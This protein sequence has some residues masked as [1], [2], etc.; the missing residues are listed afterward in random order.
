MSTE[1]PAI[2]FELPFTH[3]AESG[4]HPIPIRPGSKLPAGG[5]R[6][7]TKQ[8]DYAALDAGDFS[9]GILCDNVAGLDIDEQD[10]VLADQME[11]DIRRILKLPK[12]TPVRVGRAPKRMLI[13]RVPL[14]MRSWDVRRGSG[15][16]STVF[17][18]LGDGKQFVLHGV[19]PDTKLPYT[20][21]KPLPN[22]AKLPEVTPADIAALQE[23]FGSRKRTDVPSAPESPRWDDANIHK[24]L[25]ALE[26]L[27][28]S[29]SRPDWLSIGMAIHAGTHGDADGLEIFEGWSNGSIGNVE[30]PNNY[31]EGAAATA[32]KSFKLGR[33]IGTGT[34]FANDFLKMAKREEPKFV[35]KPNEIIGG[36][37]A[38]LDMDVGEVPWLV[39]GV[40]THGAHLLVGRPKGGKSWLVFDMV[41][42]VLNGTEFLGHVTPAMGDVLWIAAEDTKATFARRV[43]K[44]GTKHR[45]MCHVFTMEDLESTRDDVS[46]IDW[47]EAFV[48][49]HTGIR[50]VIIDTQVTADALWRSEAGAKKVINVTEDAYQ[51]SRLYD[52]VGQATETC[53]VLVHHSRK[54]NGK[55][56]TDYHELINMAQTV[57]AG[58]TAS[59]VIADHPEKEAH[60]EDARRI[61]AIRGRHLDHDITL[62]AHFDDRSSFVSDGDHR[63]VE[64]TTAQADL[65]GCIERMQKEA[66]P[67]VWLTLRQIAVEMGKHV[68]SV[69]TMLSRMKTQGKHI[70]WKTWK[71]VTKAGIGVRFE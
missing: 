22:W 40:L 35:Q 16:D 68:N 21:R 45:S 4:Y 51:A 37:D 43:Q 64:Q 39:Q 20:L 28:P 1:N 24:A 17:Q 27:D 5:P 71:L 53:I 69:Q 29:M 55:M 34:L 48:R 46:L 33:G 11:A 6:W 26:E 52:T 2:P 62:Q 42:A 60:T 25:D 12:S 38:Y 70:E 49:E 19:H 18:F 50:L 3:Y 44:R 8:Y 31:A 9:V 23:F 59:I 36:M 61:I 30:T 15:K 54:R 10:P 66:G 65:L 57:V 14:L 32:W 67:G 56:V 41:T 7:N 63:I 47:V 58:A 13:V